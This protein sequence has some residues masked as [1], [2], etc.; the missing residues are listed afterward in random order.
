MKNFVIAVVARDGI[1][2]KTIPAV[3]KLV[4]AVWRKN[5]IEFAF[6]DFDGRL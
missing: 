4:D 2:Q 5:S 3:K 6:E 1:D